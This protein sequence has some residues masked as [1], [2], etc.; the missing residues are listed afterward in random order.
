MNQN[1]LGGFELEKHKLKLSL[2]DDY[3]EMVRNKKT[4]HVN[5]LLSCMKYPVFSVLYLGNLQIVTK[6]KKAWSCL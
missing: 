2:V 3:K 4:P 1:D 5:L 6:F